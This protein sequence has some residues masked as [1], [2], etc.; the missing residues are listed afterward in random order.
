[1][2]KILTLLTV[3]SISGLMAAQDI[4]QNVEY[5]RIYEFIDELATD[6]VITLNSA[7][8]P[9]SRRFI[10]EKLAEASANTENL[11]QRQ[12]DE[13]RFF[14][15]DYALE[16][17]TL[18]K[19][20]LNL[21]NTKEL[22]LALLQPAIHYRNSMVKARITP[23]LGMD[24]IYN[25]KK[26]AILDQRWGAEIQ[27]D[28]ASHFSVWG[29]F[30]EQK[31]NGM[32]LNKDIFKSTKYGALLYPSKVLL[33]PD[34][35]RPFGYKTDFLYNH[36][37]IQYDLNNKYGGD[38]TEVRGGVS[39]YNSWGSIS[40]AKET[41]V[42]GDNYNGSNI[43][44]GRAP[45]F[46][47]LR[48]NLKPC[49]WFELNYIHGWLVSN[50]LDS[51]NYY[52]EEQYTDST[53]RRYYRPQNK[54][55]AANMMTFTPIRGLDLSIGNSVIYAEQSVQ[56]AYFIPIAFYK[57]LDKFL[58]R[59]LAVENQNSQIFFNF[60]SRNIKHLHLYFS[61]FIDEVSFKRFLPKSK[62]KNPISYK[63]GFNLSNFPLKNLSFAGEFTRSNIIVYKHSLEALT[64]ESNSIGLGHYLGDNAM[65]LHFALRYMPMRGLN[66]K[67]SYTG[68]W[69]YNDY[70][71][72]RRNIKEIISQK[73]FNQKVFSDQ[74]VDLNVLYEIF[75]NIYAHIDLRL[76]NAK[77]YDLSGNSGL[78][79][80]ENCLTAEQNLN[81]F[82]AKF[83][84][85]KNF[86]MTCG[87]FFNF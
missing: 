63:L 24:I 49:S 73:A 50:V 16:L 11:S 62:D 21:A 4:P 8:K 1:M 32:L 79:A 78:V 46:P 6:Q 71:Y 7:I 51:S 83:F 36:Q 77:G 59:G 86:T 25:P 57:G 10:A 84:Q 14:M 17:D 20:Y 85:D 43:I 81:K 65:D 58:T 48:L 74:I 15:N 2:K 82:S 40:F 9:Y 68:F 64:W 41:L 33:G 23:I 47:M 37:G 38:Y 76:N 18:P 3:L 53:A 13:I 5:T 45:S 26:G 55:I 67:L 70:D 35:T 28:I 29:S 66:V 69:K 54:Y 39:L 87:L 22:S 61:A 27:M 34:H 72:I 80:G 19:A 52:T 75:N 31:Y 42:W 12:R 30:R 44:S 56:A 60:S